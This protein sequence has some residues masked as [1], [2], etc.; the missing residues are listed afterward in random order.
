MEYTGLSRKIAD[1]IAGR[2][3]SKLEAFEKKAFRWAKGATAV[4]AGEA[5]QIA[6]LGVPYP[7][8]SDVHRRSY[9]DTW[10]YCFRLSR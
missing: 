2:A 6:R 10:M 4:T 1:Y 8:D 3:K 5:E 7:V 9:T